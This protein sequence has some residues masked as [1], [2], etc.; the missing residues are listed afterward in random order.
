M[1]NVRWREM[2]RYGYNYV[3]RTKVMFS[4]EHAEC[5]NHVPDMTGMC[6]PA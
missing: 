1:C 4:R 3:L 2:Q 5:D 6:K